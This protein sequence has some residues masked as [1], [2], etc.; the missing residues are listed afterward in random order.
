MMGNSYKYTKNG[1]RYELTNGPVIE[2]NISKINI[3]EEIKIDITGGNIT[4]NT[5]EWKNVDKGT[6]THIYAKDS[7]GNY[8]KFLLAYDKSKKAKDLMNSISSWLFE[9]LEENSDTVEILDQLKYLLYVYDG[10]DYGVTNLDD[11]IDLYESNNVIS[12]MNVAGTGYV[13]KTDESGALP[14]LTKEQLEKA[15]IARYKNTQQ[16]ENLLNCLD[17]FIEIQNKYNVNAA[18]AVAIVQNESSC[19]T[20]FYENNPKAYISKNTY[21]WMSLKYWTETSG[22]KWEDRKGTTWCSYNSFNDAILDLGAYLSQRHFAEGRVTIEDIAVKYCDEKWG[23]T[24]ATYLKEIYDAAG[25][26]IGGISVEGDQTQGYT[27]IYTSTSGKVYKEYKQNLGSY[28]NKPIFGNKTIASHGCGITSVCIVL[29]GYG[30]ECSPGQYAGTSPTLYTELQS[31]GLTVQRLGKFDDNANT[32]L[33]ESYK[34][35]LVDHLKTGNAAM[36]YVKK[37]LGSEFTNN[38]HY[39]AILDT[40]ERN[41]TT[42]IYVSNP[43]EGDET[44]WQNINRV[45]KGATGIYLISK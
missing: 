20:N 27:S 10:T 4:T 5:Q 6:N 21:N 34:S 29:S 19:G 23:E 35:T 9:L 8:E 36:I 16:K 18:L 12:L 25:I 28:A 43:W 33:S 42:E 2:C 30:I 11:L 37:S 3:K 7:N 24:V 44:A 26:S 22:T 45:Y 41:G 39:M 1:D 32:Q 15:I 14:A 17:G 13:V 40:R 38:V 31:K